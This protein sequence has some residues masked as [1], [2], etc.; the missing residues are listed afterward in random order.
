LINSNNSIILHD[1]TILIII[2]DSDEKLIF[3]LESLR[4]FKILVIDNGRNTEL[5]KKIN[6]I[7]PNIRIVKNK[8]NLGFPKSVNLGLDLIETSYALLLSPDGKIN[9]H[10]ICKLRNI[11]DKYSNAVISVPRMFNNHNYSAEYGLLPEHSRIKRSDFENNISKKLDKLYPSGDICIFTFLASIMMIN[12]KLLKRI[13]NFSE[14]FF[15]YWE[16]MELARRIRLNKLSM[17]LCQEA[18]AEHLQGTGTKKNIRSNF[19]KEYHAELSPLIYFKVDKKSF[20]IKRR[21]IKYLFRIFT[22]FFILNIKNCI[23]NL[24]K[25]SAI[26]YYVYLK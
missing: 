25:F 8:K 2:Y 4:N 18:C 6:N 14:E 5:S 21:I 11:F 10:D 3:N 22:Y 9:E 7:Y 13:G 24:A 20:F 1:I 19:I 12:K 23:K 17:I 15:M 26:F 16:D